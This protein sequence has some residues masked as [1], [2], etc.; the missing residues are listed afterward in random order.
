MEYKKFILHYILEIYILL[1]D[2]DIKFFYKNHIFDF[3]LN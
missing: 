1:L 3:E 2:L